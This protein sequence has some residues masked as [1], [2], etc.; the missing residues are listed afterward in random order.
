[1]TDE[2]RE[3]SKKRYQVGQ[4]GHHTEGYK[5]QRIGQ[6]RPRGMEVGEI[7]KD[8]KLTIDKQGDAHGI[9]TYANGHQKRVDYS[10]GDKAK[11]PKERGW[12]RSAEKPEEPRP[13]LGHY[14][15][16]KKALPQEKA[17]PYGPDRKS[18][19]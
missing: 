19:V 6:I 10:Y 11:S 5:K 2:E 13:W 18:V 12:D 14:P 16:K 17:Q 1:M 15:Y 3:K 7:P 9:Y 4:F 8:I